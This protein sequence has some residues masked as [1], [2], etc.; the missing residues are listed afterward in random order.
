MTTVNISNAR[1][2]LFKLADS[3]IKYNDVVNINTKDGNVVMLSEDEYSGIMETLH[4][5]GITGVKESIAQ[6]RNIPTKDL[7]EFSWDD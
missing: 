5:S 2:Q 6:E 1:A 3:C 7:E 4:L